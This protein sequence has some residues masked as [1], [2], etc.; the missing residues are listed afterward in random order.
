MNFIKAAKMAGITILCIAT[1]AG[2]GGQKYESEIT[3]AVKKQCKVPE[4]F[5][6]VNYQADEKNGIAYIDYKAQNAFGVEVPGRLYLTIDSKG[7]QGIDTDGIEAEVLDNFYKKDPAHFTQC[8]SAYRT[9]KDKEHDAV[10]YTKLVSEKLDKISAYQHNINAYRTLKG[11]A[12]EMN[13]YL[14]SFKDEYQA[15]PDVVKGYFKNT[16]D[17]PY[18]KVK[19]R[20]AGS[21]WTLN[22][23]PSDTYPN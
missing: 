10:F 8:V 11:E 4:S 1:L 3:E 14:K 6:K 22:T 13:F 21:K 9:L 16:A 20:D 23:E 19:I 2:C 18:I 7:F 17:L 5:K 15:A 12:D